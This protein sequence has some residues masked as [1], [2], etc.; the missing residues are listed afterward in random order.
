[1]AKNKILFRQ[2]S[3]VAEELST[4][5]HTLRYWENQFNEVMPLKRAG[6]RRHYRP[7]DVALLAGIKKFIH[8]DGLTLKAVK[9]IFSEEGTEYVR[10][11]GSRYLD[12]SKTPGEEELASPT[13]LPSSDEASGAMNAVDENS[14]EAVHEAGDALPSEDAA[15]GGSV[16]RRGAS[17]AI[18][19]NALRSIL[20]RLK[21][22]RDRMAAETP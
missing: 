22:L 1:M 6:N 17:K 8:D 21:G 14:T 16:D 20:E 13:R 3:D 12:G 9:R 18:D 10:D 2:V 19:S 7:E 11:V 4:P 15:R 5:Q